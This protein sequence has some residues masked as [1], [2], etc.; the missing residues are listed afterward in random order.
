MKDIEAE[1][2]KNGT[3]A[4]YAK[5]VKEWRNWLKKNHKKEKS[6]WLII[7]SKESKT[8]SVYWQEAVKEALCFGWIDS[9]SIK[10]DKESR[11]Q[12]YSQRKPKG[13]WSKIN[14]K[15][16]EDLILEK[17]MTAAGMAAIERAKQNGSWTALD[18]IEK[19]E[20][21]KDLKQ[22]LVRD[23]K[24][25]D[26][27]KAFPP[28]SKKIILMWIESAKRPETRANRIAETIRLAST[29]QR[30]NHYKPAR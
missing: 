16:V 18:K 5:S 28:S 12:F 21:P 27:F 15:H 3:R 17:K 10:R 4:F 25:A 2:F 14:K 23:K 24:A 8:P 22:A 20:I 9:K 26:Y 6:V 30:A 19:L 11:Y 7:Y 1:E 13:N 29:N